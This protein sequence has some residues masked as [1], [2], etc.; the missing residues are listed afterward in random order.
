V[1]QKTN[2]YFSS[3]LL[4][5]GEYT[6]IKGSDALAMPLDLFRGQWNFKKENTNE[7]LLF[8]AKY[9]KNIDWKN[10]KTSFDYTRFTNNLNS[11]L[12][13]SSNIPIGYGIG[14]SGALTAAIYNSYFKKE[15]NSLKEI[16]TILAKIESYFHGLSSGIDPLVSYLNKTIKITA[17]SDLELLENTNLTPNKYDLFLLDTRISRK[18]KDYVDIFNKKYENNT[19][20]TSCIN[21]L[22]AYNNKIISAYITNNEDAVFDLYKEISQI[23]YH[24]FNEMIIPEL[25]QP[26]KK[27]LDSSETA[28]KLC[29]AGGGG[30]YLILT[31][32]KVNFNRVFKG[33]DLIKVDF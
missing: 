15:T 16:N 2:K 19:F 6:I 17:G 5:F 33:F 9:L 27:L 10:Y 14:S 30:F 1:K 24:F 26:W 11:G 12:E 23:Q 13:F 29:G 18:T 31:K 20:I 28:I 8:Y 22:T 25:I 4:L 3:K 21:P 7:D 32:N